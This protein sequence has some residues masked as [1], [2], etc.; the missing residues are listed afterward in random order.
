MGRMVKR[1]SNLEIDEVSV[2]DRPANQHGMIAISKAEGQEDSM[3]SIF[4]ADGDEV[5]EDELQ[6]GDYVYDEEGNEFQV[7]AGGGD[8]DDGGGGEEYYDQDYE[9]EEELEPVGKASLRLQQLGRF[10][11]NKASEQKLATQMFAGRKR[12]QWARQGRAAAEAGGRYGSQ[13][14]EFAGRNKKGLALAGGTGAAAAAGGYGGSRVG[15]SLG[16]QVLEE[17]SKA[18]TDDDRDKVIAKALDRVGE[19]SKR[20]ELLEA[21]VERLVEDRDYSMFRE[22]A[23][24]YDLP[25]SEDDIAGLL[26]RAS[27]TLPETDVAMLDRFFTQ[28]GEFQKSYYEEIGLN[29]GTESDTLDQ[30]YGLAG[31][32]VAKNAE[33]GLTTEQAVTALFAANPDAY[34][35]YEAETRTRD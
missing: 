16:D 18:Y 9:V 27:A 11:S 10:A 1:L 31:Q 30:I 20:N 6:V 35:A 17:L 5:F 2:V 19:V 29:G 24:S 22:V 32:A 3:P 7:T 28:A 21:A 8:D 12:A 13:A 23:K 34:D 14:R 26:Q 4:D 15:K 33:M 25:G